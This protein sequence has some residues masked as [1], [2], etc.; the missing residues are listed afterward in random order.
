MG[1]SKLLYISRH[2]CVV[3]WWGFIYRILLR[4]AKERTGDGSFCV[5]RIR[6]RHTVLFQL[7]FCRC[8]VD[9]E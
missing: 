9:N 4:E 2:Y 5:V 8:Y 3:R 6:R 1:V 7:I